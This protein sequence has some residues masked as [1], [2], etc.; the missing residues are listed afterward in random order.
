MKLLELKEILNTLSDDELQQDA[1]GWDDERTMMLTGIERIDEK[2]YSSG[3]FYCT[4][5]DYEGSPEE[6]ET[7]DFLPIGTIMLNLF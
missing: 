6:L 2:L 3:G 7:A 5:N 1:K 4:L